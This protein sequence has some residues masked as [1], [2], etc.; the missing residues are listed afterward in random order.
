MKLAVLD[1]VQLNWLSI[2]NN[3][4]QDHGLILDLDIYNR[5][6][7]TDFRWAQGPQILEYENFNRLYFSSRVY[8]QANLPISNVY[9]IDLSLD[10]TRLISRI[11][12]VKIESGVLGAFDQ[13]GIFPFHPYRLQSGIFLALTCGWKRMH[14]V[15]IDMSIGQAISMDGEH[16]AKNG[17]GPILTATP[18]EPFLVGDPFLLK[19]DDLF[20]LFYI[21]G[22]KWNRGP[23]NPERTYKIGTLN[24]SDGITFQRTIPGVQIIPDC[25]ENE[26]QAM[27]SVVR[28]NRKLHMFYCYRNS[29]NFRSGGLDSYKLGYAS[30]ANGLGWELNHSILPNVWPEWSNAMQCYP[31]VVFKNNCLYLFYNGNNFGE[32]GIGLMT[33]QIGEFYAS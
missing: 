29:F 9:F 25:I 5:L 17:C 8:D 32:K 22:T 2:L 26:A 18:N 27:P 11:K 1:L 23:S 30:S 3:G 16:F 4:W 12:R 6:N 33:K 14:S 31:H 13:H 10:F 19:S 28:D 7:Q 15:D 21:F 20:K 24:S